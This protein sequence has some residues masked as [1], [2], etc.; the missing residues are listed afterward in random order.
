MVEWKVKMER[1]GH[2][3]RAARLESFSAISSMKRLAMYVSQGGGT[4][5]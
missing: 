2:S 5:K 4:D 1:D 3:Q